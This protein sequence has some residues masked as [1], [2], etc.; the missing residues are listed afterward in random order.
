AALIAALRRPPEGRPGTPG[1]AGRKCVIFSQFRDTAVYLEERL[2]EAH[3]N[4]ARID[5]AVRSEARSAITAWF[6]PDRYDAAL[7]SGRASEPDILVSTDVLAEGHNLQ[8][9]D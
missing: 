4:V 3:F 5:G 6:D 2:R 9:A 8:R 1:L 7:A